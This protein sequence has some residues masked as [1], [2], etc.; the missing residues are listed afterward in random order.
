MVLFALVLPVVLLMVGITIDGSRLFQTHLALQA[1][2]DEA[3][4]TGAQQVDV[5]GS[6]AVRADTRAELILGR[7][8]DSAFMAAEAYLAER[9]GDRRVSWSIEV[10][11][12]AIVVT[13][14]RQV[15]LVMPI[16]G[17]R[18]QVVEA[19]SVAG[20]LSGIAEPTN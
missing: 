8:R 4:D 20:P 17:L 5:G 14:Q 9:A 6:S 13:V 3:A 15:D 19:R 10:E 12:R 18:Q 11:R 7:G 16:A 1:L 2:A